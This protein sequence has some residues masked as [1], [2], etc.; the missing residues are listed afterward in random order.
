MSVSQPGSFQKVI[1]LQ[2]EA[3]WGNHGRK[4]LALG[5]VLLV[6]ALWYFAL[7]TSDQ[8]LRISCVPPTP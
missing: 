8:E 7:T 4:V 3:F 6:Y 1:K 5:G 2:L